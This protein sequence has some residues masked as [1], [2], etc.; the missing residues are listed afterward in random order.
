MSDQ[1]I[2]IVND[3]HLQYAEFT[4]NTDEAHRT[5]RVIAP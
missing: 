3:D 5:F 2:E 4:I 1:K